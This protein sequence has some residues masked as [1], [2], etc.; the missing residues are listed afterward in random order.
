MGAHREAASHYQAALRY[1]ENLAA[2]ERVHLQEQLSYECHLTGQQE[3]AIEFQRAALEHWRASGQRVKEGDALRWLSWLSWFAGN[4]AEANRYCIEAVKTLESLPPGPE[5]A[6][7]YC[8]RADLD[9]EA[10]EA[11]SAID[12]AQRAIALAEPVA[13]DCDSESSVEY[14]SAPY[15]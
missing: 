11:D 7:A 13:N 10:H 2:D 14:Y 12:W 9:M 6:M 8:I 1:A 3:R 5:L 4:T 15:D